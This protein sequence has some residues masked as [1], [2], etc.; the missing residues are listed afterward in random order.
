MWSILPA[1]NLLKT[2]KKSHKDINI[3]YTGY[4]TIKE[5]RDCGNIYSVNPLYLVFYSATGYFK[6]KTVKNT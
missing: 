4:V 2:N 5:F 3:Y 1:V 6:E